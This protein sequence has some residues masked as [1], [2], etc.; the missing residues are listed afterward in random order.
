MDDPVQLRDQAAR[1]LRLSKQSNDVF[2]EAELRALARRMEQRA[3]ELEAGVRIA[4]G[5]PPQA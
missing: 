4:P 2:A 1:C 5:M 3:S